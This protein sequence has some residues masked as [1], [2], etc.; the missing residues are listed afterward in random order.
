MPMVRCLSSRRTVRV[1][2]PS[3]PF[4]RERL[5]RGVG[6]LETVGFEVEGALQ[7]LRE[8]H[9]YLNGDDDERLR[10]LQEALDSEADIV[11]LA[12]GGYGLTRVV[13]SLKVP[14]SW[15]MIVGFSDATALHGWAWREGAR[16][17][18]GPLLTTVAD[19][20]AESFERL[21]DVLYGKASG[22]AHAPLSELLP[23]DASPV[24]G[25]LF[26]GN[27]CVLTHLLA[28]PV[29]PDLRGAVVVLEEVGE[30]PYR[31]D[32]MLTQ[33]LASGAL[34][35]VAA[36]VLGHLTRCDEPPGGSLPAPTALEVFTERLGGLG[37]PVL[38][39][40]PAGHEAPNHPLIVGGRV[41]L[42]RREGTWSLQVLEEVSGAHRGIA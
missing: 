13:S 40:L 24:E 7:V 32:R 1:V 12:R 25:R 18:H 34:K 8:S 41:R 28:T 33:L 39:G 29:W 21:V 5:L 22:A 2:G 6:R 26:A 10:E 42:E 36:V 4:A 19:E 20:P 35:H 14:N 38:A 31:I 11:W 27:L 23:G 30:R 9:A 3:S 17:V 16:T 37:V 15:P